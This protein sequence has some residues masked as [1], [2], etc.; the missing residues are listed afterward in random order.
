L[1]LLHVF[2]SFV[3]FRFQ[4]A[5]FSTFVH[6]ARFR[7]ILFVEQC[8]LQ[9]PQFLILPVMFTVIIY[10]CVGQF[11]HYY[12]D[13][14]ARRVAPEVYTEFLIGKSQLGDQYNQLVCPKCWRP[15]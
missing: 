2:T 10:F 7:C 5:S 3:E 12:Y 8:A 9:F 14:A 11:L 1:T 6:G 13:H 15:C 4:K